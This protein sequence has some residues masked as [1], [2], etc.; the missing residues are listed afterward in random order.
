MANEFKVKNGL[1]VDLGG[2]TI[3]GSVIA[4]GGFTGSLQGTASWATNALTASFL[5]GSIAS[6]S[7][8]DTA[9]YVLNSVSSS[10]ALTASFALNGGSGATFPYTGSAII[11]GSLTVTGSTYISSSN[12]TQLQVGNNLLFVSGSGRIGIG[13]TT[14][15]Y[16][17][18]VVDSTATYVAQFRGSNSSYVVSGDTSLAGESGFNSRNS[19]G[20][21][22]LSVS[23]SIVSLTATSGANTITF[24]TGGTEKMRIGSSG[25]VGIG[26]TGSYKLQ[27]DGTIATGIAGSTDGTIRIE[28]AG[29]G[30]G[31]AILG[32]TGSFIGA[33]GYPVYEPYNFA[34]ADHN[35]NIGHPSA[36]N[37]NWYVGAN[38]TLNLNT[39]LMRLTRGGNLLIGTTT[40]S[41]RLAVK[42]SGTT[43]ATTA[44]RVE[45]SN[46]S[47]SLTILD[48]R[49]ATFYNGLTITGSLSMTG[50]IFTSGYIGYPNNSRYLQFNDADNLVRL[51][52]FNG[53]RLMTY[54][55]TGYTDVIKIDGNVVN[56]TVQVTGSLNVSGSITGS[57]Q[58]TASFATSASQ[59]ITASYIL[60]A[61]SSSFAIL[62]QTS[63]TASYVV[64]AQTASYVLQAVSASFSTLSQT[65]NTASYVTTAQT[66]S[67][68]LNAVSASRATSSSFAL[69]A[70]NLSPAISNDSDTRI[71]T[72]NGDGTLNAESL[73]TFDG[74]KLSILYQS[75]DEGG[76]ILLN[77]SVTNNSLTGSGITVDSFQNKIR[78]FEQGG[79]ARGAY[80]DLTACAGGV[81]TNLL[82]GGGGATFNGGTNVDNRLITATGTTPELNG[83][84]NLTFNG[85]T[86]AVT[87]NVTAT[88]I[89]SSF[90][91][92]LVGTLT[93]TASFA[94]RA[95]SASR[96]DT[97][98]FVTTAQ[99]ASYVLQAVSASF[100]T[101]ASQAINAQ[102]ASFAPNYVLNSATSSFVQ[103]SQTSS[104]VQNSQ[105]SSMSVATASFA[106]R[107][108]GSLTGS[109]LG[110]ASFAT[111]ASQA[112]TA[113]YILQAVSASF[114]TLAR[115]ADTAS[116]L[117]VGTYNITSSWAVS[118]SQAITASRATSA[119]YALSAS[120]A[121]QVATFPYTGSA[122]ISGS[123]VITGS[124]QVGVPSANNPTIDSTVGTLGRGALISVDW[125]NTQLNDQS[126]AT[127]VDWTNR[128]LY[129]SSGA[130]ISIDWENRTLSE[131]TN[132]Y[133]ALEYSSNAYLNSQLYYRNII[134]GAVQR[135]VADALSY[136]GQTIQAT[137]DASVLN[138]NLVF[139]DTN[140]TWYPSKNDSAT[141]ATKMQGI[142]VDTASGYVLLE[143][144][145]GVSDDNS[146][147]AYVIGAD[148]GL[149]VYI[150]AS[151]G[152]M[153]TTTPSSGFIRIV[154]HIYQQSTTDTNWWAMKFRPSNDWYEI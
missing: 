96:A 101:S 38:T 102:T 53:I 121:P 63:N 106:L 19:S 5:S 12:N 134:P 129:D 8:A 111:S 107:A 149:P 20:Q 66:A 151:T 50:S 136:G 104:F 73:L 100:A 103:N 110:T 46:A 141:R 137:V 87:G 78:F 131:T 25:N 31:L 133:V 122:I 93:G 67:Y 13:T 28:R 109:L 7:Y 138:Y 51:Q 76:E 29:G 52:G 116:F 108:S 14:P 82:T 23:A 70:S 42:G 65:A 153:T 68:V 16:K 118:A 35:F 26:T 135:S 9:S 17:L 97:A 98:S 144:D 47:A 22:F 77:K 30:T 71:T 81:G 49:S 21:M 80:I 34:T 33:G 120:F 54:D 15:A 62:A 95:T 18:E 32:S 55:T 105:T 117:P 3:T 45:N 88:S 74:T 89:T 56:R 2:A 143:G 125:I 4:T 1:I 85:S 140:G 60:N 128:G 79:A 58:G 84:G 119:S 75:G 39:Q 99:T 72:A 6:A 124:L 146:S 69:T 152:W 139:L 11:S 115:T 130:N 142:C 10:Y 94:D 59:A 43:S 48:D 36:G 91:G 132:T 92:S 113:S 90:T 61:V 40:D 147:G 145:I 27:V 126:A 37:Y 24:S 44:L 41:A 64:T 112:I 86:L 154:G 57:L 127:S 114:A 83:E 150:D 123:L 148:H